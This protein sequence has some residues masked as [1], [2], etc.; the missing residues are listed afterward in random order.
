MIE[1]M[2]HFKFPHEQVKC[3]IW[4]CLITIV[5]NFQDHQAKCQ[6]SCY[7]LLDMYYYDFF[8]VYLDESEIILQTA[9]NL[10]I[11]FLFG[12]EMPQSVMIKVI[13]WYLNL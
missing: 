6:V 9:V 5:N 4:L 11:Y 8:L 7:R 1:E 13:L 2:P 12:F 10:F 3:I